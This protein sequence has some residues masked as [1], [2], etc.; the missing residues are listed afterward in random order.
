[1]DYSQFRPSQNVDDHQS[2]LWMLATILSNPMRNQW[3]GGN[4][5]GGRF[6]ER[7]V[8]ENMG[9]MPT[10]PSV[11]LT[12]G[13]RSLADLAGYNDLMRLQQQLRQG[14]DGS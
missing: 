10:F 9:Q 6:S 2:P 12:G 11:P 5:F 4:E 13:M 3:S 14:R 8:P 1:M 7:Q